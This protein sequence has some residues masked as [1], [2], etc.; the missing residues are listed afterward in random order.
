MKIKRIV[1]FVVATLL[2][3]MLFYAYIE[4][5]DNPFVK[6]YASWKMN[7]YLKKHYNDLEY[8]KESA[9]Y[10]FK[11]S[12]YTMGIDVIGSEDLDFTV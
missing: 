8:Q 2:S 10:N 12:E 6:I 11:F 5:E 4:F 1:A 9:S 7:D 3:L